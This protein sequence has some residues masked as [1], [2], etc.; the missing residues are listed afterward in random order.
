MVFGQED[1]ERNESGFCET[2]EWIQYSCEENAINTLEDFLNETL[3][4]K[5]H[6]KEKQI[7]AYGK[8]AANNDGSCGEK[9]HEF[10]SRRK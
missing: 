6:S 10:I 1:L 8:V 5:P 4:G 9:I 2:S 3:K 7:A